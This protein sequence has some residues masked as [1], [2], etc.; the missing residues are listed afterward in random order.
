MSF[1]GVDAT[2]LADK[3]RI[4]F[5]GEA[6]LVAKITKFIHEATSEEGCLDECIKDDMR[7][8]LQAMC[9]HEHSGDYYIFMWDAMVSA[10][11]SCGGDH[12]V[13]TAFSQFFIH[14]LP[15]MWC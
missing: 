5:K 3:W 9:E 12:Y 1:D 6:D 11:D 14:L 8:F 2:E 15:L 4:S 10:L 7:A 13:D